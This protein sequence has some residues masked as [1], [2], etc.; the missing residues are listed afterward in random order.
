MIN[1]EKIKEFQGLSGHSEYSERIIAQINYACNLTAAHDGKFDGYIEKAVDFL[2]N[3]IKEEGVITKNAALHCES[4]L[5][6]LKE[7]A[8]S[9]TIHCIAHAHIDMNWM[10]GYHETVNVTVDTF[11]TILNLMKEYPQFTFA[12][13][14]AST[15]EIIEKYA[16]SMLSEIKERVK[17]G[18]WEVSASTW[19]ET[20]K[21]MPSGE[22]LAR[23]IIYTKRYLSKLLDISESSLSLDFE[24]DTFGHNAN[25]PE[26]CS[27]GGVKYYYHCRGSSHE[28]D[29]YVWKGENGGELIVYRDPHWY[30]EGIHSNSFRETPMLCKKDGI[31]SLL[32][33]YG[34]G[35]HGGGPTRRDIERLI[36]MSGWPIMPNIKFSSY[37]EFFTEL[38]SIKDCLPVLTG[39]RNFIFDGCY[40]SQTRI[41]M[42]NRLSEDR[43]FESESISA[44]SKLIGGESFADSFNQAWKNILFNQFHD[45]L[46]G[47]GTVDTREH[48]MGRF[49]DAM[50]V[51]GT[52]ANLAMG[53]IVKNIDTSSVI[54]EKDDK[55]SSEGGG[56]G[57]GTSHQEGFRLPSTERGM[58]KRRLFHFF[59]TTEYPFDGIADLTVFDWNYDTSRAVFTYD[60][61][62]KLSHQL[63]EN[64]K[65]YWGHDYKKFALKINVPA[66]GYSSCILDLTA[67]SGDGKPGLPYLRNDSYTG[68]DIILENNVIKAVFDHMT[69]ELKTL[70]DK[71][72]ELE[73]ISQPSCIFSLITENTIH[74][75]TSWRVGDYMKKENLN[76]GG[77]VKVYEVNTVGLRKHIKYSLNFGKRSHLD[78][79]VILDEGDAMLKFDV[80]V[81]FHEVGN[82]KDGI[83]QLAFSLPFSYSSDSCRFDIPFG[84]VDRKIFD[85]DVPANSFAMP[86][87]STGKTAL[88]L[89][90]NSKYG[91]RYTKN[92][93]SLSLIRGSF[94]PDP[95]PEYG[96]HKISL[97]IG[98]C[99]GEDDNKDVFEKA[100]K[101]I[102]PISYRTADL[103]QRQGCLPL[104]WKFIKT[105]GNIKISAIKPA[106][107][108]NGIVIRFFTPGKTKTGY[109]ITFA[110]QLKKAYF[111]D[112]NEHP[113]A[114]ANMV[115]NSISGECSP[116]QIVTLLI[117]V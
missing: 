48:A 9:N 15:Y 55:S 43:M 104:T 117:N 39:E 89:V 11:R 92:Q 53:E 69:M 115:D 36:K 62:E 4:M 95:Y 97:G 35:D 103:H 18:R 59:N 60:N 99:Q 20:D 71:K 61:G 108:G 81:D 91:F 24:P 50:A 82:Q 102:H 19:V 34:V 105:D 14:Q 107:D 44:M 45:I 28:K 57:Y 6:P 83:P 66:F 74:G 110:N 3:E 116:G 86:I 75:M 32:C 72:T 1:Y 7:A 93:L 2:V 94:D 46:P 90:S 100:S 65:H 106:E 37:K 31:K 80:K 111:T 70:I 114:S 77:N 88:M 25:V 41:K 96:I 26:I 98:A 79:S 68:D 29:A 12:Q 38:E 23:H 17:D 64:G 22:S 30:S 76:Q 56:T 21:N 73:L 58:G 54:L 5:L 42:A 10:W 27:A 78:V 13:S 113:I 49:Q 67:A 33:V 51:I 47:S 112:L 84:T 85:F 16:P 52:N 109:T 101:F 63:L 40:T 87:P 8:K